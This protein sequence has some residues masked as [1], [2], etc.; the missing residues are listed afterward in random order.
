MHQNLTVLKHRWADLCLA[1]LFLDTVH[2]SVQIWEQNCLAVRHL[3]CLTKLLLS[4]SA[5]AKNYIVLLILVQINKFVC[6]YCL[7]F[8][9]WFVLKGF[10]RIRFPGGVVGLDI[11]GFFVI[12]VTWSIF[13]LDGQRNVTISV[14]PGILLG[15]CRSSS[16]SQ[17]LHPFVSHVHFLVWLEFVGHSH[18]LLS[19]SKVC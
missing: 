8:V 18:S 17:L 15:S 11:V 13:W 4:F 12:S 9:D 6:R 7:I 10:K 1:V 3:S 16:R 14:E 2:I 5:W 19:F